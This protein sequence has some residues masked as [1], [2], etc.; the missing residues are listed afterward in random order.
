MN[1]KADAAVEETPPD[2]VLR[3]L[4][5]EADPA[6]AAALR[7]ELRGTHARATRNLHWFDMRLPV[8]NIRIVHDGD[9]IHLV[10]NDLGA[11]DALAH[12][13]IGY[14][15]AFGESPRALRAVESVLEGKRRGSEIAYLGA[16]APFQR[17]VLR[18][19]ATIPRGEV[20]PYGWV[21]RRAG[22]AGA[23]RA[24][25]T[26]LGHNPVP[27]IVPCHRV[28]RSDWS[29]GAYSAGGPDVK[30]SVLRWEGFDPK[31]LEGLASEHVKFVGEKHSK[32][33]CVPVCGGVM[34]TSGPDIVRFA[35]V[36]E[37]LAAGFEPCDHCL[38]V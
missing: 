29:L 36:D 16:V 31:D 15:P 7:A 35:S 37:A 2:E 33:F 28:I 25:G 38:P 9:L 14:E 24:T 17:A 3:V 32:T 4:G 21:A 22:S 34:P 8:G 26:A 18:A 11:F 13:A 27:F 10:T 6:Y 20:R 12:R 5:A 19:T 30:T 23:V 1:T